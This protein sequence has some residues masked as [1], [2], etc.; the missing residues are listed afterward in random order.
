M[1]VEGRIYDPTSGTWVTNDFRIGNVAV[2]GSDGADV[3][4]LSVI[5]LAGGNV[6]VGWAR[7]NVETGNT[8]PVY[9]VLDQNGA[10]V[11]STAEVEGADTESQ[12]TVWE[13]PPVLHALDDGRFLA[14]W[15]NDG[16]SD[17]LA[18]MTLE[19]RI[20]NADGTP[21]TGDFRI[22]S[23]SVDGFDGFDNDHI[24][25]VTLGN[26]NVVI[27]YVENS[28]TSGDG[29]THSHFTI[30]NT[31]ANGTPVISDVR[32]PQAPDHPYSGPAELAALGNS[33]YFV[34]VFAEGDAA[35]GT[36]TGL[37]YRIFNSNGTAVTGDVPLVLPNMAEGVNT[38]N[39]FD[40][41]NFSVV[42]SS[43]ARSFTVAWVGNDDGTGT[44]A[45]SSG[46]I[47]VSSYVSDGV[48]DGTAG[49]DTMT[50]GYQDAQGDQIDGADGLN[51]SI[52]A[53]DGNDSVS[54]GAGN[55]SVHGEAGADTLDGGDGADLLSGGDGADS[56]RG[57]AGNDTL[58]GG[59]DNDTLS[60]DAGDDILTSG[61]GRDLF[62]FA[63]AGGADTITDFDLSDPDGDGLPEDRLD[64]SGLTDG[65]GQPVTVENV[66][67]EDL[68]DGNSRLVFPQGETIT[69]Q[70]I[71]AESLDRQT[72][73]RMGIPCFTAGTL[74]DTPAGP[75]PV[76]MLRPGDLVLTRDNG[77]Q[78]VRWSAMRR[79]FLSDLMANPKLL[80]VEIA[81]GTFG[82]DK[83]MTVSPQHA[84]LLRDTDGEERLFRAIHLSRL[85]GGGVRQKLG[86]R[87]VTYVHLM[88]D[89][90]QILRS[91]GLWSES[92]Y[93][94]PQ[95]LGTL[96]EPALRELQAIFPG[97]TCGS[98]GPQARHIPRSR[99]LPD[100]LRD[101]RRLS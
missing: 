35:F 31:T 72:L 97:L 16:Y 95:A 22:G 52:S 76:Q 83:T 61:A 43:A 60:G 78:P 58:S 64:V 71:A 36:K 10:T 21:A 48:V 66:T 7:N 84:I 87:K 9:T 62:V 68:G 98:Y 34:A 19:G 20:F 30:L 82:N 3:P 6:V 46:P 33:G 24:S 28:G 96:S 13:S 14:L 54:A 27:S 88:F 8:E 32:I 29:S 4:T 5:Q 50:G 99:D 17:D 49:N 101:L 45:F 2:D 63:A 26:G 47:N 75:V 93:P 42:Y 15:V 79:L 25:V 81:A 73:V 51:D 55:D 56:L 74:I 37:N 39:G 85:R 38:D 89:R 67:V 77:P 80:P 92:F 57:G 91:G 11:F 44:G 40:W 53:G 12:W 18:S 90:N 70:G 100:R 41:D 23:K 69:L 59:D 1:H 86:A 65:S 94:G